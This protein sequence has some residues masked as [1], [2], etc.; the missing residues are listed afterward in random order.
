MLKVIALGLPLVRKQTKACYYNVIYNV[1]FHPLRN[2]P[3]PQIFDAGRLPIVYAHITGQS[4]L[5]ELHLHGKYGPVVRMAPDEL[6]YSDA[7]SWRDIYAS[8]P[9][10]MARDPAFYQAVDDPKAVPSLLN[11]SNKDRARI[12]RA[13]A[14]A[15]S[16]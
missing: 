14:K 1:F 3:G 12:R 16:K 8:H 11:A 7:S 13:Y 6:S 5:W 2:Y 15:F 9:V 10:G 4:A